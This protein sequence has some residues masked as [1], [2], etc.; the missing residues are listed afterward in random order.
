MHTVTGFCSSRLD[1]VRKYAVTG[2]LSTRFFTS[3]DA[4]G[5]GVNVFL[6]S[7]G[8]T[9]SV[10]TYY[11]GGIT[12]VDTVDNGV[13]TT[14]F[15]FES[16]GLNDSNN[17][18]YLPVVKLES[19][20]NMVENPQVGKDVFIVRQQQPVFQ[21]NYRLR[22]INSLNDVIGYAGGNYFTIFNNT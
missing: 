3:T 20:Q 6:S 2:S 22:A 19:K 15:S 7:E 21:S 13:T 11:I 16:L 14:T 4:S 1:E 10:Y 5:N 9:Q 8:V 17:F 18:D 12:Y